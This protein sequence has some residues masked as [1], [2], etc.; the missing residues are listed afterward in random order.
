VQFRVDL[1]A[2]YSTAVNYNWKIVYSGKSRRG[3]KK[4]RMPNI[5][6]HYLLLFPPPYEFLKRRRFKFDQP[7]Q[8]P[9]VVVRQF[10]HRTK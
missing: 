6:I 2:P 4:K 9:H 5:F 7:I 1:L 10:L 3:I 8:H